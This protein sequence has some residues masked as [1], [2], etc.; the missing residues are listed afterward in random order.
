M[1]LLSS[2]NNFQHLKVDKYKFAVTNVKVYN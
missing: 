2:C 1:R